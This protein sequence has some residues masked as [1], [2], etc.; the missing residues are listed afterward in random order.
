[1]VNFGEKV[2][3]LREGGIPDPPPPPLVKCRTPGGVRNLIWVIDLDA[4]LWAVQIGMIFI[5]NSG[6][7]PPPPP[8]LN[9]GRWGGSGINLVR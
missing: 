2:V 4:R 9:S 6:P 8:S 1:M 5:L 3:F 7:P